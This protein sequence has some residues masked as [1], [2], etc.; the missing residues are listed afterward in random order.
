VNQTE[1]VSKTS[2]LHFRSLLEQSH[3]RFHSAEPHF[4]IKRLFAHCRVEDHIAVRRAI[5]NVFHNDGS[6]TLPLV[7]GSDGHAIDRRTAKGIV[8]NLTVR[9]STRIIQRNT[10]EMDPLLIKRAVRVGA[11]VAYHG[12]MQYVHVASAFP[13]DPWCALFG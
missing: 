2:F 8:G 13:L 10:A 12:R 5:Q 3:S 6:D 11:R 7:F 9:I 4:F 1:S